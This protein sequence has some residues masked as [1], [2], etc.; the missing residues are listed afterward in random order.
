M[1]ADDF[2]KLIN[3]SIRATSDIAAEPV[4]E[5]AAALGETDS[6]NRLV[7]LTISEHLNN[8]F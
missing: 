4:L 8:D 5:Q 6:G 7:H 1:T 3:F 2:K